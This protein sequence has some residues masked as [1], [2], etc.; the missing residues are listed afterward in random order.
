MEQ[1]LG[2][3]EDSQGIQRT[4]DLAAHHAKLAVEHIEKL[5]S[6]ENRQTLIEMADY[7]LSRLN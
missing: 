2:L 1:A 6:S 5:P 7:V 4:Q 3:V